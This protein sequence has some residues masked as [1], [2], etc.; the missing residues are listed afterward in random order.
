MLWDFELGRAESA[1]GVILL[2][3]AFE[4]KVGATLDAPLDEHPGEHFDPGGDAAAPNKLEAWR[5]D[6]A[7]VPE[8]VKPRDGDPTVGIATQRETTHVNGGSQLNPRQGWKQGSSLLHSEGG[9]TGHQDGVDAAAEHMHHSSTLK[10][11][12]GVELMHHAIEGDRE[13]LPSQHSH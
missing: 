8:L 4:Q 10:S 5:T 7:V 6:A 12:V 9:Q 2:E 13:S 11:G 1:P 3:D